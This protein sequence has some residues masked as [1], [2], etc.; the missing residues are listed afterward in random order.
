MSRKLMLACAALACGFAANAVYAERQPPGVGSVAPDFEA[1]DL[2]T[3]E[4]IRLSAQQGKL[5]FLTFWAT[6]CPPCRQELPILENVQ[7]KLGKPRAAVLAVSFQE[8]D[9]ALH[10]VKKMAKATGWQLTLLRDPSGHIAEQYAIKAIPHLFIIGRDGKILAVHSGY[11]ERSE[12][13][14][15]ELQSHS[16]LVCRLLLEKK[17]RETPKS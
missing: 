11:G 16:D 1:R 5:V 13:H 6:W 14:T 4:K 9:E 7:K 17:K 3:N 10:E 15:S 12:E 2:L 8:R